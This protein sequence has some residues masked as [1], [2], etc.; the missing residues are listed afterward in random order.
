MAT[1]FRPKIIPQ[2]E[3]NKKPFFLSIGLLAA[4]TILIVILWSH[5]PGQIPLFYSKP[6]GD[7]Q[8]ATNTFLAI[9]IVLSTLLLIGNSLLAQVW[10][11]YIFIR[12]ILIF[13][14]SVSSIF[15]VITII[16]ILLLTI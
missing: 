2:E 10:S 3:S 5:I 12:K 8:L 14:A 6:W 7:A 4:T 15:A 1:Q 13:G 11:E 16:R 9:P